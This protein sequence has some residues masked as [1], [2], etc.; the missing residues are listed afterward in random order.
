[1]VVFKNTSAIE[2]ETT[3]GGVMIESAAQDARARKVILELA[4]ALARIAAREDDASE[5]G[6]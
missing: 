1:M 6:V 5:N 4:R 2:I 3:D